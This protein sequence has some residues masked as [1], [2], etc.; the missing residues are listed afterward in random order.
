MAFA[1][2]FAQCMSQYGVQV[3]PGSV[4][5]HDTLKAALEYVQN[6]LS[7]LDQGMRAGFDAATTNDPASVVLADPSVNVAPAIPGLLQAFDQ[8][9]GQP[10]S[11]LLQAAQ[12]CCE[13]A[14]QSSSSADSST[15]P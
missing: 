13:N 14:A 8:A 11:T 7:G 6:W 2:D 15:N 3:D 10:I 4:P 5:D 12:Y 9:Q 1:D